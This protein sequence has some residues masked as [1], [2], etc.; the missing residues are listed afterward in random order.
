M[1]GL[2]KRIKKM[3][4]L[5]ITYSY[6]TD[7]ILCDLS[8]LFVKA[9]AGLYIVRPLVPIL[10]VRDAGAASSPLHLEFPFLSKDDSTGML[11]YPNI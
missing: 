11:C 4:S 8:Y 3:L 5:T 6:S 7:P 10:S 1:H 2:S 9:A